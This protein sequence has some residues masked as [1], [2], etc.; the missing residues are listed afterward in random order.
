M[1]PYKSPAQNQ[2]ANHV[3]LQAQQLGCKVWNLASTFPHKALEIA[4]LTSRI[5]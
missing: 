1:S 2:N 4:V 3:A 5:Y